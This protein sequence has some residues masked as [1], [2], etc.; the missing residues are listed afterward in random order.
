M[1]AAASGSNPNTGSRSRPQARRRPNDDAPYLGGMAGAGTKRHAAD[2]V[3]GEPRVKRKRV[4]TGGQAAASRNGKADGR[5]TAGNV[6]FADL[7]LEAL[8]QYLAQFELIPAVYPSPLSPLDPPPPSALDHPARPGESTPP[9][10]TTPAN[11]PRRESKEQSRRRSSRLVEEEQ[12]RRIPVLADVGAVKAVLA[13]LAERHFVE[14][15]SGLKEVDTLAEFMC[16][17]KTKGA[18]L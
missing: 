5:T 18:T 14:S 2:R 3:E 4:D 6:E 16:A 15:V 17:V 8:Y 9:P 1:S 7:P 13:R 10:F 11:R 12:T